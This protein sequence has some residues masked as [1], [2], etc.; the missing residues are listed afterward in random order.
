MKYY[1]LIIIISI[2]FVT[3]G[4]IVCAPPSAGSNTTD[5]VNCNITSVTP[6]E[7]DY[8]CNDYEDKIKD[9]NDRHNEIIDE[10][11]QLDADYLKSIEKEKKRAVSVDVIN[12]RLHKLYEEYSI[13]RG[14]LEYTETKIISENEIYLNQTLA[15]EEYLKKEVEER[16]FLYI[17]K[18]ASKKL[19]KIPEIELIVEV[20]I[21]EVKPIEIAEP[22]I[23]IKKDVAEQNN[24]YLVP[25]V[26]KNTGIKS[27]NKLDQD[28]EVIEESIKTEE[29]KN[30]Q[31]EIDAE[32]K[33][34]ITHEEKPKT[35]INK[36]KLTFKNFFLIWF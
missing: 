13:N 29:G 31:L 21:E 9:F 4:A 16:S 12:T 15:C 28:H 30:I 8:G 5:S 2:P 10:I 34:E 18:P 11:N 20:M 23:F 25:D 7:V 19:S 3:N 26:S 14:D 27:P 36:I 1:L 33:I 22:E 32:E 35:F 17:A 6:K 24:S